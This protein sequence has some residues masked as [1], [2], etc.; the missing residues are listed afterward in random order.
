M[1]NN[2]IVHV[3]ESEERNGTEPLCSGGHP[4]A[5]TFS[6]FPVSAI[7]NPLVSLQ[8]LNALVFLKGVEEPLGH[9]VVTLQTDQYCHALEHAAAS[10][11]RDA[12]V[13]CSLL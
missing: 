12:V 2:H 5:G 11:S 13:S 8:S 3:C 10:V 9:V 4:C 7:S 6:E 1:K